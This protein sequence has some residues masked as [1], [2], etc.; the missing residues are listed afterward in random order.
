M[1]TL[2]AHTKLNSQPQIM[3]DQYCHR[4]LI[5]LDHLTWTPLAEESVVCVFSH[6]VNDLVFVYY[7]HSAGIIHIKSDIGQVFLIPSSCLVRPP[8]IS[9]Q[10]FL[11]LLI[12]PWFTNLEANPKGVRAYGVCKSMGRTELRLPAVGYK[13]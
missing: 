6:I 10:D 13:R 5:F 3:H 7:E 12:L 9:L 1:P 4:H 8:G 11:P 2:G